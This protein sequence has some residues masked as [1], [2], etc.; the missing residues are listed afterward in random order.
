VANM[1]T[2][3]WVLAA[4]SMVGAAVSLLRPKGQ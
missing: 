4:T 3:L 2:A 1:R